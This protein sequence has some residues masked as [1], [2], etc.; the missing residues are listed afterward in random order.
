LGA[1][2]AAPACGYAT[3]RLAERVKRIG[4]VVAG[5]R[6]VR[7]RRAVLAT[8]LAHRAVVVDSVGAVLAEVSSL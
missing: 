4:G 3:V 6:V 1:A 7:Q 2:V 5:A 8:V